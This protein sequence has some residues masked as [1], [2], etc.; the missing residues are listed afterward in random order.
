MSI[1]LGPFD[2]VE[3]VARGGMAEVWRARHRAQDAAVA[4]KVVTAPAGREQ[5]YREQFVHEVQAMARLHHPAVVRLHEYGEIPTAVAIASKGAMPAGAPFL[6]MEWLGGG[7]L[8]DAIEM[9]W[10]RL[11]A[12]MLTLL[13]ALAH[14]HAQGV[15]HR[16]LKPDNVLVG[17][18]GPVL[19]DFGLAFNPAIVGGALDSGSYGTPGY[20]APEQIRNDWR[21]FGP[22]TDLYALGCMAYELVCGFAPHADRHAGSA[23]G[24]LVAHLQEPLP[25]LQ[26]R[27]PVP[28]AFERWLERLMG[29]TPPARFQF[30]ADAAVSLLAIPDEVAASDAARVIDTDRPMPMPFAST[31]D[32]PAELALALLGQGLPRVDDDD[33]QTVEL[34]GAFDLPL[35][36]RLP[37]FDESLDSV[38]SSDGFGALFG[39]VPRDPDTEPPAGMPPPTLRDSAPPIPGIEPIELGPRARTRPPRRPAAQTLQLPPVFLPITDDSWAQGPGHDGRPPVPASWRRQREPTPAPMLDVGLTLA[40]LRQPPP[41]GREGERDHLWSALRS[42]TR[43]RA[44]AVLIEGPAGQGKTHLAAWLARRAHEL[45]IAEY[46]YASHDRLPSPESGPAAMIARYLRCADLDGAPRQARIEAA[47]APHGAPALAAELTAALPPP[48]GEGDAPAP[49][50]AA[51]DALIGALAALTERRPLVLWCDD[52]QWAPDTLRLIE[53]LLDHHPRL[54]ILALVT[55]REDAVA[56]DS[57]VRRRLRALA[58]RGP[59]TRLRLGPLAPVVQFQLIRSLIPLAPNLVDRLVERTAGSPQFAVELVRHWIATGELVSTAAGF[60]LRD[61]GIELSLPG[62]Q[63][64][65]WLTRLDLALRGVEDHAVQALELAAVLGMVVDQG[66]WSAACGQAGLDRPQRA[67]TRLQSERLVRTQEDGRWAFAHGMLREALQ[68]RA[69]ADGR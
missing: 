23:I 38:E 29:R 50:D 62:E 22:W 55:I 16:D 1:A 18:R 26:P 46:L 49:T 11:R 32:A 42:A 47:L 4:V 20:M 56:D 15:V 39:G 14:A 61:E 6:V 28:A 69:R 51:L 21:A 35:F 17:D 66:E 3:P 59:V 24:L 67:L 41:I 12:T 45:G 19:T 7:S 37:A 57:P 30:A 53:R 63:Q 64:A 27:F 43:G 31:V 34:G 33:D 58:E 60:E 13:D 48:A 54:P 2:L 40:R 65:M 8:R 36:D 52:G 68:Q 10:P 9:D 44:R 25:A 5:A